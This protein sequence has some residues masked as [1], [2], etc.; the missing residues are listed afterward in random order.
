MLITIYGLSVARSVQGTCCMT[1]VSLRALIFGLHWAETFA[2]CCWAAELIADISSCCDCSWSSEWSP[3]ESL[4][5]LW[6][7]KIWASVQLSAVPALQKREPL[8]RR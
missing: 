6:K 2:S 1:A 3:D 4:I 7:S 8:C 5:G